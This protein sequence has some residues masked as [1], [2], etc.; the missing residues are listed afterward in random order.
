MRGI[1]VSK[2]KTRLRSD[3]AG[4]VESLLNDAES[5]GKQGR[6]AQAR[7]SYVAAMEVDSGH[8]AQHAM[9]CFLLREGAFTEAVEQFGVLFEAGCRTDNS[10]LQASTSNNL[11]CAFREL[12]RCEEA[13]HWQQ[14]SFSF[15]S[16]S[17][18][19]TASDPPTVDWSNLAL[20]AIVRGDIEGAETLLQWSLQ[21]ELRENSREGQAS[22]WGN[23][24]IV[25]CLK[26]NFRLAGTRFLKAYRLHRQL[27]DK[28]LQG[29]DL[30]HLAEIA[31]ESGRDRLAIACLKRAV[32]LLETSN[33]R[34]PATRAGKRLIEMTSIHD[35]GQRDPL[36]N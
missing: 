3:C 12:G 36:L 34:D 32:G 13:A 4:D 30:M 27:N 8:I 9:A 35:A 29:R 14:R 5:L 20:D 7:A 10:E 21:L 2:S 19:S 31:W 16:K 28:G 6:T 26:G 15:W 22:D 11:A 18:A 23:L 24:G 25:A 1:D 33:S 17:D